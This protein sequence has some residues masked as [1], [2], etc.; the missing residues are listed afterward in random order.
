MDKVKTKTHYGKQ[1]DFLYMAEA[2]YEFMK[3]NKLVDEYSRF[4]VRLCK[5]ALSMTISKYAV[6]DDDYPQAIKL[7]R[8]LV[9]KLPTNSQ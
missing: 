5:L 7:Y 6:S 2:V 3:K 8:Q 1:F 9:A 4:L